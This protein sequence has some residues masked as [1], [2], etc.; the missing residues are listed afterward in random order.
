MRLFIVSKMKI[1]K[2]EISKKMSTIF[3]NSE[4]NK[5]SGKIGLQRRDSYL[6]F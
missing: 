5:T 1:Y 2:N 4:N 6:P 3:M